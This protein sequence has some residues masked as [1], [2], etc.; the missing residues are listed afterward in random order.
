MIDLL[1]ILYNYYVLHIACRKQLESPASAS[2]NRPTKAKQKEYPGW[3]KLSKQR[4]EKRRMPIASQSKLSL[5]ILN[6]I[7]IK[8]INKK[9]THPL[10]KSP[11]K[12]APSAT[13][14]K[15]EK[16]WCFAVWPWQTKT[17]MQ[18][19][20][21]PATEA[22]TRQRHRKSTRSQMRRTAAG[23]MPI[24][25]RILIYVKIALKNSSPWSAL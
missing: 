12:S 23:W 10:K 1:Y 17:D 25:R 24:C 14:I 8:I 3:D 9:W 6:V 7:Q 11:R 21:E 16:M 2:T 5:Q 13:K 4:K 19:V 20:E 18:F 15:M 22:A